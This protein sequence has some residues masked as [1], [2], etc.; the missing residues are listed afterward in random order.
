M[1]VFV[2]TTPVLKCNASCSCMMPH[3]VALEKKSIYPTLFVSCICGPGHVSMWDPLPHEKKGPTM[4]PTTML[5]CG[6]H[7]HV[8]KKSLVVGPITT[9]VKRTQQW[10]HCDVSVGPT[11]TLAEWVQKYLLQRLYFNFNAT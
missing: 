10:A 11:N 5:A 1:V 6:S 9:S 7:C 8:T 3:G 2:Y 4:G